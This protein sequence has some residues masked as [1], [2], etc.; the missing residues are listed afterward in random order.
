MAATLARVPEPLAALTNGLHAD[1]ARIT[2]LH[3]TGRIASPV[4]P[5]PDPVFRSMKPHD[6][7][8]FDVLRPRLVALLVVVGAVLLVPAPASA[9]APCWKRLINDWYDGRIDQAY[10]VK[11]YRQAIKNLPEDVKA[12]SSAREDIR[13]ALLAAFRSKG[14]GKKGGSGKGGTPNVP[15][16]NVL[17]KPERRPKV[18]SG[19]AGQSLASG[20]DRRDA[21]GGG[22]LGTL[23]DA[24]APGNAD[25]V[26]LPLIVLAA[27]AM[28]LLAAAGAGLVTRR[29]QTRRVPAEPPSD[30]DPP[31]A[32][33]PLSPRLR[34]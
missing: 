30:T 23:F 4:T 3:E 2:G 5:G 16:P 33:W 32:F 25:S 22:P 10:P 31:P 26:P 29:F 27:L 20:A 28:L 24:L 6:T 11:C 21:R 8:R 7:R 17:V 12:Y 34:R 19:V 9:A 15:G 1:Y 18:D 13:R 14:G